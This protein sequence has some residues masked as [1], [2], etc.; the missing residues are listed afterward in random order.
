MH[1]CYPTARDVIKVQL[2]GM[3]RYSMVSES[4]T[5]LLDHATTGQLACW[6]Q[7]TTLLRA[8]SLAA[9]SKTFLSHV[10]ILLGAADLQQLS[11]QAV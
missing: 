9:Y 1:V 7:H 3:I 10:T 6:Q 8:A 2:H 11:V 4:S 5:L